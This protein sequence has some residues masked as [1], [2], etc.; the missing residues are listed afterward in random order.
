[1][2]L[3][4]LTNFK[5]QKCY[6]N[7]PGFNGVSSNLPKIKDGAYVST[8]ILELIGLLMYVINNDVTYFDSFGVED[9][10]KEI[11]TFINNKDIKTNI[12]RTQAF[13]SI[14][15]GFFC[16]GFIDFMIAAKTLTE[17]TNLFSPKKIDNIILNYFL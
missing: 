3:H 13:D 11:R 4:P 5:I 1:M 14:M 8:P 17:F 7:E 15:C 10:P 12:F 9:V 2:P 6:R 16:I